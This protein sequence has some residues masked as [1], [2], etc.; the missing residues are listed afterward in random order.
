MR[1]KENYRQLE[2]FVVQRNGK[3]YTIFKVGHD[4]VHTVPKRIEKLGGKEI[5]KTEYYTTYEVPGRHLTVLLGSVKG[6]LYR[7]EPKTQ[8]RKRIQEPLRD[9]GESSY[10][11]GAVEADEHS[12]NGRA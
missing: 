9:E 1:A 5:K 6:W 3:P 12:S 7:G 2:G 4:I 10:V 11:P 8:D